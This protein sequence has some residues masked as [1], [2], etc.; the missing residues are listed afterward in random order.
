MKSPM[1]LWRELTKELGE[2]C[3]VSTS[4]D[5][6]TATARVE[7]EGL[8]FLTISLPAFCK[9]FEQALAA[10][11][12]EH[13]HFLGFKRNGSLPRF[14]GGFFAQVFD[15]E[16]GV[17]LVHASADAIFAI[18]Q[19]CLF[20]KRILLPCTSERTRNAFNSYVRVEQELEKANE[21]I[22]PADRLE[23]LRVS[24][25]LFGRV[26]SS[27]DRKVSTVSL[28]P[29]HGPGSTADKLLGNQKYNQQE[30]TWR[31]EHGGFPSG[32][33][34]LPSSRFYQNLDRVQFLDPGD[35]R[36][37][38]VISVPK[39]LKTPR[40]IAVEPTAMQYAQQAV[41][42]DLVKEMECD[43]I[44]RHFVGFTDQEPNQLLAQRGSLSSD[45][46]TLDL[47]EASDRVLNSLV[48]DL[49][50]GYT[51][52]SEAV[53]ACRSL[54]A[55]VP[56]HGVIPLTKFA[57]M[58]SALTFPIEAMVFTSIC[59]L[60]IARAQ[61]TKMTLKGIRALQGQVRVYGD[62]IIVPAEY[63]ESVMQTLEAFG[64]KVNTHKSFWTG[65][66]RESCGRDFWKG[67]DVTTIKC[68]T[69]LPESRRDVSELVSTVSLRN[70]LFERGF[71]LV[72]DYLDDLLEGILGYYPEVEKT[73]PLLGR[74]TEDTP[75]RGSR[76][77]KHTHTPEKRGWVES[78]RSPRNG[79]DG[80]G[81]LLKFFLKQGGLPSIEG[82][83]ER[84]GR[85]VAV[86]IKLQ[87]APVY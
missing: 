3:R 85:P 83:L 6:V 24:R 9:D 69:M 50:H 79:L 40:I 71:R 4:R 66:F 25:L 5:L 2:W 54:T 23:L 16:S 20:N 13:D 51:H 30:W 78:S 12:I 8:S 60:G 73:S 67:I 65:N 31:L 39:T 33:Y 77:N 32:D 34:L 86:D 45:L 22:T 14:L 62:D 15:T 42:R 18:R 7:H 80:E 63:A 37:V 43:D 87:W 74:W 38:K 70:N 59:F 58:G 10:G 76:L 21:A 84:S 19:I 55:D 82:H 41:A 46:A 44:A 81:A 17:L 29:K 28:T 1:L 27:M 35:E 72:C 68:S 53:Q 56:G 48:R 61:E 64:F 49:F 36:P 47:S 26:F 57:S 75:F 52:L 11:K